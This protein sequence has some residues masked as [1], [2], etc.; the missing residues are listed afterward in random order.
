MYTEAKRTFELKDNVQPIFLSI[1]QVIFGAREIIEKELCRFEK[2]GVLSKTDWVS[3][4]LYENNNKIWVC[5][6][7]TTGLNNYL[8]FETIHNQIR[9][10]Y[11]Q[12]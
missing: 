3:P 8:K 4:T 10:R 9:K 5:A 11:L 2:I 7:Y 12:N 1:K 6:D